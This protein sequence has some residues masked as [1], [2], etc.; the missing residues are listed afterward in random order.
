MNLV[1]QIRR[2]VYV[3]ASLILL[4]PAI[5]MS[6]GPSAVSIEGP[7]EVLPSSFPEYIVTWEGGVPPWTVRFD[8]TDPSFD[9]S[10][11]QFINKSSCDGT[12]CESF[13]FFANY[14]TPQISELT[15]TV[16]DALGQTV[17]ATPQRVRVAS[18]G[19]FYISTRPTVNVRPDPDD[20]GRF[21]CFG[22][23]DDPPYMDVSNGESF[24]FLDVYSDDTLVPPSSLNVSSQNLVDFS[25]ALPY[26]IA[27][28][29]WVKTQPLPPPEAE[30]ALGFPLRY[31]NY[32]DPDT[33]P[34]Q[35]PLIPTPRIAELTR[36]SVRV[37]NPPV[38]N[39][40]ILTRT[41]EFF[42]NPPE[43]GDV[44]LSGDTCPAPF[45]RG[46]NQDSCTL[47]NDAP[48]AAPFARLATNDLMTLRE[49]TGIG[50]V[51]RSLVAAVI[52]NLA[53]DSRNGNSRPEEA[54]ITL[55]LDVE[56]LDLARKACFQEQVIRKNQWSKLPSQ[57]NFDM[58]VHSGPV[59]VDV[60]EPGIV[61]QTQTPFASV[62]TSERIVYYIDSVSDQE[63]IVQ[64]GDKP[65][66]VVPTNTA[67]LPQEVPPMF[68]VTVNET[69]I[70]EPQL[71]NLIFR[72]NFD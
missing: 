52:I 53:V 17:H 32:S 37:N 35:D 30:I 54:I 5:A 7:T 14:S 26:G 15:A 9:F 28:R 45:R 64:A 70:S 49:V 22:G 40:P 72:D 58:F 50:C 18:D 1:R 47:L 69:T 2:S 65:I 59:R 66:T 63:T 25:F 57:P 60:T 31:G 51:S 3:G 21:F 68:E 11:E 43:S 12:A 71:A 34:W 27:D 67:L 10:Q 36:Y 29:D 38:C 19:P 42:A 61:L 20:P 13:P 23:A 56:I 16:I 62:T 24:P 44:V 41:L 4:L 46:E 33:L 48:V 39:D 6:G 55:L 8:A